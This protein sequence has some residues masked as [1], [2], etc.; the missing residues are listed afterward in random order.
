[1]LPKFNEAF[2]AF[3]QGTLLQTETGPMAIEDLQP[4]QVL[5][6][7]GEQA[8]VITWIG[9]ATF[10]PSDECDRM[11][12][13]RVM[14]D[15]FGVNRPDS[16][17]SLGSAARIL[18]TPPEYR[19]IEENKQLMTPARTFVDGVNVIEVMPPTPIRLF[20]IGLQRHASILA[21]GLEV[22]SYHPGH[23]P[24]QDL[25][26]TLRDVFMSMFPHIQQVSDFGPMRFSRAPDNNDLTA[27]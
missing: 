12:L 4:G 22:E 27:A 14:A 1:M 17:I 7:T 24:L 16:F 20:H 2:A 18:K 13:T 3:A 21:G 9:S 25:S 6:T 8:E 26:Q 5:A 10:A 23:Q 15:S 19:G 11:T